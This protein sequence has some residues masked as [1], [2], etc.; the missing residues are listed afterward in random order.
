M[1]SMKLVILL[2]FISWKK[3]PNDAVT[4]QRQSQFT[5]K[6]TANAV[7]RLLSS[8]V[9]IDQYNQCNGITS[10]MKFMQ[11]WLSQVWLM[12]N[13]EYYQLLH[14]I[15]KPDYAEQTNINFHKTQVAQN[16]RGRSLWQWFWGVGIISSMRVWAP[17]LKD[18]F[19]PGKQLGRAEL[20][21]LSS[22]LPGGRIM[23]NGQ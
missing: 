13:N 16:T 23:G 1:N 12:A 10:F 11:S 15:V 5:P 7:P 9:W 3:T 14:S 20:R 22:R 6:M 18:I 8:L 4:P 21:G 17:N 19:A 2:H